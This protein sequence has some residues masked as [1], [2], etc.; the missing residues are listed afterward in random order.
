LSNI[1]AMVFDHSRKATASGLPALVRVSTRR[2]KIGPRVTT[3]TGRPSIFRR[4]QPWSG[5]NGPA[6]SITRLLLSVSSMPTKMRRQI[7]LKSNSRPEKQL[8]IADDGWET[9][10]LP[11]PR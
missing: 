2:G 9:G 10:G 6:A 1:I 3:E 5:A 8:E 11:R 4:R 7:A